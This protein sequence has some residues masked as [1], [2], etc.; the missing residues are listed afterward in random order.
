[1]ENAVKHG[2]GPERYGGNLL[3]R[4]RVEFDDT[5]DPTLTLIVRDSGAGATAAKLATGRA[6]GVGL[7]N[8]ERRLAC[9]YGGTAHLLVDSAPGLGTMVEIRLPAQFADTIEGKEQRPA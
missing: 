2:I 6:T 5:P 1:V 4:A 8:I 7:K 3:V 9:H